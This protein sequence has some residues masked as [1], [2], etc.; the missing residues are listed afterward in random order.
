MSDV[1]TSPTTDAATAPVSAIQ[2]PAAAW[3]FRVRVAAIAF[4][5][6]GVL[7]AAGLALRGPNN[8]ADVDPQAFAE[9][10][11]E[12]S[13]TAAWLILLPGPILLMFAFLGIWGALIGTR[14]ER[15][16]F[17]G[18]VLSIAGNALYM[19]FLGISAFVDTPAADAYLGGNTEAVDIVVEAMFGGPGLMVL[20]VSALVLVAGTVTQA[21]A[22]WRSGGVLPRWAAIP[23]V[24]QVLALTIAAQFAYAVELSGGV[25][26]LV[27]AVWIATAMWRRTSTV[28]A[29]LAG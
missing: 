16:A 21:V 4:V 14:M 1:S 27:S 17:W 9:G 28:G 8:P 23:Y 15:T 24:L 5:L 22:I 19:P 18:A 20:L 13:H 12:A 6:A 26:L 29:T 25:L 3:Q 7:S 11:A 10:A 2:I